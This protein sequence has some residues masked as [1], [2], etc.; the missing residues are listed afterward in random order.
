MA[1]PPGAELA[2]QLLGDGVQGGRP[3]EPRRGSRGLEVAG[4]W[5]KVVQGRPELRASVKTLM[6]IFSESVGPSLA[7][8]TNPV[9]FS[10]WMRAV[11]CSPLCSAA[12]DI[13]CRSQRFSA[14]AERTEAALESRPSPH[15]RRR[16]WRTRRVCFVT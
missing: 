15:A 4:L 11:R 6:E 7:I 8:W 13:C 14:T 5:M 16:R 10:L 12:N 2:Q 9:Q 1:L 3:L